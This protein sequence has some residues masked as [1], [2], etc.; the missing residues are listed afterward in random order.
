MVIDRHGA[1]DRDLG[2]GRCVRSFGRR[3]RLQDRRREA[4]GDLD[5]VSAKLE[6]LLIDVDVQ[7]KARHTFAGGASE[8]ELG[9]L[10]PRDLDAELAGDDN[11]D[12]ESDSL[13]DG[14]EVVVGE[15][16][17][18]ERLA[19]RLPVAEVEVGRQRLLGDEG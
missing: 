19:G 10:E 12:A 8:N 6:A 16:D 2:M 5:F 4:E 17:I 18:G 15:V 9:V 3:H 7:A 13:A 1:V 11:A 14:E